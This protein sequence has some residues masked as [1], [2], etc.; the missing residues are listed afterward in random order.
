MFFQ[1]KPGHIE[2][3]TLWTLQE[4]AFFFWLQ[5]KLHFVHQA[6]QTLIKLQGVIPI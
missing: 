4:I 3:P 5:L 6:I 2:L 1:V